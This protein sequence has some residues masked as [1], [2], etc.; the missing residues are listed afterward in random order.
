[1]SLGAAVFTLGHARPM[2]PVGMGLFLVG[3]A[4]AEFRPA[5]GDASSGSRRALRGWASQLEERLNR[6]DRVR[7]IGGLV[8]AV[9]E[10][11]GERSATPPG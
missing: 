8:V 7:F 10:D 9:A 5:S 4:W 1:M 6:V 2:G 3:V 11:P